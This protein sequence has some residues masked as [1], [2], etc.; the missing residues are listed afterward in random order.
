MSFPAWQ[1]HLDVLYYPCLVLLC[2][3]TA[4][5]RSAQPWPH[6]EIHSS[7]PVQL[8]PA[9]IAGVPLNTNRRNSLASKGA[10]MSWNGKYLNVLSSHAGW[11]HLALGAV[12]ASSLLSCSLSIAHGETLLRGRITP[13]ARSWTSTFPSQGFP[14]SFST[15]ICIERGKIPATV[16]PLSYKG[17]KDEVLMSFHHCG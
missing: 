10:R 12:D 11:L 8:R 7:Q 2:G 5:E 16:G 9:E 15:Q 6:S 13:L 1:Q 3:R 14:A 17:F 4:A